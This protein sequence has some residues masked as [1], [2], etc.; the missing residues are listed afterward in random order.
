MNADELHALDFLNTLNLGELRSEPEGETTFP[1]FVTSDNVAIEIRRLNKHLRT[2]DEF[3]PIPEVHKNNITTIVNNELRNYDFLSPNSISVS[4]QFKRPFNLDKNAKKKLKKELKK[5]IHTAT[6][7]KNFQVPLQIADGIS[8]TLFEGNGRSD[9]AYE[10]HIMHDHDLGG[11]VTKSRHDSMIVAIKEK[12]NKIPAVKKK[13][14][15][16]WLILVDYIFS[17]VDK[18][19]VIDLHKYQKIE[20]D[21]ERIILLHRRDI[22]QWQDLL[23]WKSP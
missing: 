23:P 10:L 9:Q 16:F 5:Q 19:S 11:N 3:E 7:S 17:R 2:D 14:D 12:N 22:T 4:L 1:D 8:L 13:F 6:L 21:F 20:S 15:E 18:Y